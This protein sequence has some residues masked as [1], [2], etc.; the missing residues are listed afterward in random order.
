LK[1]IHYLLLNVKSQF[2]R[3]TG[4]GNTRSVFKN[5]GI[6]ASGSIISKVIGFGSYP[7]ITRIYSPED[8]GIFAVFTSAI[9]IMHPFGTLTYSVTIPLPRNDELAIN[10]LTLG[11]IILTVVTGLISVVLIIGG[12]QL[13]SLFNATEISN[14]W[15][16]LVLGFIVASIFDLLVHW[17]TRIKN[18]GI[19][20]KSHILQTVISVATQIGFGLFGLKPIGLLLGEVMR[21][22]TGVIALSREFLTDFQNKLSHISVK[23]MIFV[24][25][26]YR[27]LP[28]FHLPSQLLSILTLKIPL[29]FFAFQYG[30]ATAGQLGLALIVVGIPMG[31]LGKTTAN[32]YYAEISKMGIKKKNEILSLTISL[33]KRLAAI[34]FIPTLVLLFFSPFLFKVVFG[35][36]WIQAGQFTS[37]LAFYLFFEFLA[38]PFMKIFNVFKAQRK[39]LEISTI[40]VSLISIVFISV[41]VWNADVYHALI[42]YTIFMIMHFIYVMNRTY[43]I[44]KENTL[45]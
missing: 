25:Q 19:V 37:I 30:T 13:F 42:V 26:Y 29:L 27:D 8:F 28:Y 45:H 15:W 23:R 20:A 17:A 7:I 1:Y 35:S 2:N 6:L 36:E 40:R 21:K 14:Y 4:S 10:I 18:F 3:F 16:L 33:A 5:V 31:L 11:F 38:T 44:I 39:Y 9:F 41:Y 24:F 32:A 12:N 34:S 43:K 22:A